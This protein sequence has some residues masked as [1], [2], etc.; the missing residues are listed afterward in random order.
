MR[1][2]LRADQ[3]NQ[4]FSPVGLHYPAGRLNFLS[5]EGFPGGCRSI[6]RE[7]TNYDGKDIT[8][9]RPQTPP[10][11]EGEA[12]GGFRPLACMT[13]RMTALSRRGIFTG[14]QIKSSEKKTTTAGTARSLLHYDRS[15]PASEERPRSLVPGRDP[16]LLRI[17]AKLGNDLQRHA[18]APFFSSR[19]CRA[20]ARYFRIEKDTCLHVSACRRQVLEPPLPPCHLT[21][22]IEQTGVC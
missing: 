18:G 19:L 17:Q 10:E 3:P 1:L 20:L 16:L 4:V 12:C 6:P 2:P 21:E 5:G 9:S 7:K 13:C 11:E 14:L 8:A 15:P 22:V